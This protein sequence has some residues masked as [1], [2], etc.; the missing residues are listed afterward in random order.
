MSTFFWKKIG[1]K[2]FL[3]GLGLGF[4]FVAGIDYPDEKYLELEKEVKSELNNQLIKLIHEGV[5]VILDYGFW[6]RKERDR[7]KEIIQAAGGY[8][9]LLYFKASPETLAKRLRKRNAHKGANSFFITRSM[10]DD[11]VERF[12][13]PHKEAEQIL[14]QN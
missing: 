9:Q 14:Y 10:L 2:D 7:Y 1:S 6:T 11:F 3:G 8:W 13:I 5:S 12:E 4:L